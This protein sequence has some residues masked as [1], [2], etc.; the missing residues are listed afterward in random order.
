MKAEFKQ[1]TADELGILQRLCRETFLAA[2][3]GQIEMQE[4]LDY[5]DDAHSSE[6]L[7]QELT[8]PDVAYFFVYT[9]KEGPAG[10]IMLRQS[11]THPN[12][13]PGKAV[14]LNRIY[15]LPDYWGRG[16]AAQ[17]M[18][19]CVER[20]RKAGAIWLWLQV[21]QENRRAIAF[22]EKCRFE[23]FGFMAFKMKEVV[24]EDWVMKRQVNG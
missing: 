22:Y 10:F 11:H 17:M 1:V 13:G 16:L 15:L 6:A 23:H 3:A 7:L 12:L 5:L 9:G 24:H 18:D 8:D 14:L 21:W 19:F 2:Y 20:A 4:M